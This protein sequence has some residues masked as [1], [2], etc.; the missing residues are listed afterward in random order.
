VAFFIL[1]IHAKPIL[2][3][4]KRGTDGA[5]GEKNMSKREIVAAIKKCTQEL[6]H[7]PNFTE[8]TKR[9]PLSRSRMKRLFGSYGMAIRAC[10]MK[11]RC[12]A[13]IS[14]DVLFPDWAKVVRK[15]KRVPTMYEYT[16]E[17]PFTAKPLAS[18]CKGWRRVPKMMLAYMEKQRITDAWRDVAE[19]IGRDRPATWKRRAPV[20]PVRPA[21]GGA[22]GRW[23]LLKGRPTFGPPMTEFGMLCGPENENGVLFLFGMLAWRLGFAVRKIQ[24]GFPDIVALRKIDEQTWQEVKV[25]AEYESR[26]FLRHGHPPR[27]CDVLVC[28][29][30]NWPECPVEV[31]ELSKVWRSLMGERE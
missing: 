19:A 10:G 4:K 14:L 5:H 13:P 11:H 18:R 21:G 3:A 23:K 17:S 28:W 6:G 1:P 29:I 12:G 2:S 27:G 24:Q 8:L 9:T 22:S 20:R 25:E 30:H 15:L 16:R 7:A 26:N 31:I